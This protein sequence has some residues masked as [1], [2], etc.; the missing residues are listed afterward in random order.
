ML[1]TVTTVNRQWHLARRPEGVF[2][3]ADFVLREAEVPE[4]LADGELLIRLVYLSM[5]PTNRVWTR[6]KYTYMDPVPVDGVMR[7]IAMGEVVRSRNADFPEGAVVTGVLGWEDYAVSDGTGLSIVQP[8]EGVP[9]PAHFALFG[10]IGIPAHVGLT[11]IGKLQAGETLVVSA[12]AGAVGSLTVQIGKILGARVVA[13]A[14]SDEKCRYLEETLGAD[15]TI[16]YKRGP[17]GE[18]MA[19]A[20]P[21]GIDV[22]F[23]NVGGEM[24]EAALDLINMNA[25][26]VMCG[27]ISIYNSDCDVP[28]PRNLFNLLFKRARIEGFVCFDYAADPE[29]WTRVHEDIARWHREGRLTYRLDIV[30]GLENTPAAVTRLFTG[31]NQGKQL[32]R[33][34]D[35]P[36]AA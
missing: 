20:C 16:N 7:G 36:V 23:D 15:A 19:A 22:Y 35:E 6:E 27:A 31:A 32:V 5:D 18:A 24:L 34:A 13:I 9:L 1:D 33:V 29:L 2:S 11:E 14:G 17:I 21:D 3:E 28:G 26:I 4:T 8:Q 10:H 30:E 12:A 25:R